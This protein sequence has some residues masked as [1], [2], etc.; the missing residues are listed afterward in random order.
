MFFPYFA[1]A[2]G[3]SPLLSLHRAYNRAIVDVGRQEGAEVVDLAASSRI[4]QT[5]AR[6]SGTPC[7]PTRRAVRSSPRSSPPASV[8]L[9]PRA[10][11]E[12]RR[13]VARQRGRRRRLA[14]IVALAVVEV[15]L[16][17]FYPQPMGVWHQDRD[18]LALHWPGLVTYLPQFGQ[19]VSFNSAGMRDGEHPVEKPPG[20]FRVLVLG[21]LVHR[22]AAGAV[23]GF[24]SEPAAA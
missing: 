17:Y 15:G 5:H 19:S 6:T 7:T 23:R 11:C 14:L 3:V 2:Y 20:V 21:G 24:V 12:A 10:A 9:T 18:G 16:R 22:S 1:G 4:H 13:P 8:R